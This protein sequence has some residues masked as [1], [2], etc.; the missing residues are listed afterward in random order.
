MLN[1]VFRIWECM[2]C[3]LGGK[4]KLNIKE[5]KE[6]KD[7]LYVYKLDNE[8]VIIIGIL[9]G[10][11]EKLVFFVKF[12]EEYYKLILFFYGW[13]DCDIV[14]VVY[15]YFRKINFGVEGL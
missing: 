1:N 13:F 2:G 4:G 10:F 3:K 15:V 5:V 6:V 11:I 14:Y 7:F 8:D 9:I 12:N